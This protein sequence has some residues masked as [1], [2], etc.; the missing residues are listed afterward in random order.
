MSGPK[1]LDLPKGRLE[2]RRTQALSVLNDRIQASDDPIEIAAIAGEILGTTLEVSRAG[3]GTIDTIAETILIEADWNAQGVSSIAGTLKFR[4]H[5]SYIE[6]LKRGQTAIVEDA[7]DDP[8]THH[9][10]DTLAAISARSFINMP[11]TELGRFVALIFVNHAEKRSWTTA[12]LVFVSEVGQRVRAAAE[13]RRAEAELLH[14]QRRLGTA[15]AIAKLGTCEWEL[16][17]DNLEIDDRTRE[18][19]GFGAEELSAADLFARIHPDDVDRVRAV[20]MKAIAHPSRLETEY[21]IVLPSG[22]VRTV[23]STNDFQLSAD[24]Q[25]ERTVGVFEDV[26]QRR[27]VEAELRALNET[28]EVRV[29]QRTAEL[30]AAQEALR[31]SLRLEAIGQLTGGVAHDFNNLLTVI[32]GSADLLRR[33]NLTEEKRA[34][35]V[36]AISITVARAANL[37]KQLLAFARRQSLT[38]VTFDARQ[39]VRAIAVIA[40][41]QFGADVMVDTRIQEKAALVDVDLAQLDVALANLVTNAGDAMNGAGTLRLDITEVSGMPPLRGH[42]F[43]PGA[44]IAISVSDTGSGIK[45]ADLTRIF[46]PFFSTKAHCNRSGL[47]LSQVF[48]FAKQSGGDV[49]VSSEEGHGA[50]FTLYLPKKEAAQVPDTL[51]S[52]NSAGLKERGGVLVVDDNRDVREFAV[53]MLVE[54]GYETVEAEDG[55]AALRELARNSGRFGLVFSDVMMPGMT[56]IEL[57]NEIQRLYADLPVVLASG[58]SDALAERGASGF[59]LLAKPYSLDQLSHCLGQ[60][61]RQRG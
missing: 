33:P 5:G 39:N 37:T 11:L 24:G 44:C 15:L 27:R 57:G 12:E 35:Y 45:R 40:S 16:S 8:R 58:Y 38:P 4:D 30:E 29:A 42:S 59:E 32:G 22:G 46:E 61:F 1:W 19:F 52:D 2:I 9:T 31:Q 43:R 34:R 53:H 48:G 60:F 7:Y 23:V 47:G 41:S 25:P 13:R 50:T 54:L 18:I 49:S 17:T 26:T 55:H 21:R 56:G 14:S 28:L 20:T 10:A 51:A 36:E 3:Y 6:D